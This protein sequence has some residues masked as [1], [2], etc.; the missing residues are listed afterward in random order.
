MKLHKA[1]Q[2]LAKNTKRFTVNKCGRRFGKTTFA[3]EKI[4]LKA[5]SGNGRDV[6]YVAPTQTQARSIVWEDLKTRVGKIGIANEGR[7]EMQVPTIDGGTSIIY[8]KGWENRENF[9]GM[10]A[11]HITFDELDTMRGFVSG[12][13][14]IF[15]PAL[16]DFKG[17]A[18]FIGTPKKENPNLR[19]LEKIAEYDN[20]YVAF[21]FPS[22]ANPFIPIEEIEKAREE[23]DEETYTQEYLAIYPTSS[24]TLFNYDA[25]VDMFRNT[26]ESSGSKYMTVDVAGSGKD[27]TKFGIWEDK[28]LRAIETE[29]TSITE[30]IVL[31]IKELAEQYKIPY[32]NIAVDAIGEGA[33]VATSSLLQGIIAYKGSHSPFATDK[34]LTSEMKFTTDFRNLRVQCIYALADAV[35]SRQMSCSIGGGIRD[36]IIEELFTYQDT[37][38]GDGKRFVTTKDEVK[39]AIGRSPDDSDLLQMRMYFDVRKIATGQDDAQNNRVKEAMQLRATNFKRN[40]NLN[41]TK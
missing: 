37:S 6:F 24:S 17:S 7:L 29:D 3:I 10:K 23:L 1:Q 8:I 16:T 14:T 32:K 36:N 26:T 4:L 39:D 18:D 2:L 25:L 30:N 35:N 33:G 34:S 27:K 13:Q 38:K 5:T 20:D 11:Y 41:S 40:N 21:H 31:R 15:R 22:S 28:N 9:R 12:Y 19:R